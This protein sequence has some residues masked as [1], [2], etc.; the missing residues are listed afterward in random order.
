MSMYSIGND[1]GKFCVYKSLAVSGE[2]PSYH[3]VGFC[4]L[5]KRDDVILIV[6][7]WS[8]HAGVDNL[9]N[10]TCH[11]RYL[12]IIVSLKL[13]EYSR[14]EMTE[15]YLITHTWVYGKLHYQ[16]FV[17]P[18]WSILSILPTYCTFNHVDP[19][20]QCTAVHTMVQYTI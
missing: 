19:V 18:V 7:C 12:C 20:P 17:T 15:L 2:Q 9:N 11:D 6:V 16:M 3:Y 14:R 4:Y 10:L 13:I 8:Y 5:E 1:F